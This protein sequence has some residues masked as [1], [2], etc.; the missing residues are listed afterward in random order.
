MTFFN[1]SDSLMNISTA[2][3]L[4]GS[5]HKL[6]FQ[7]PYSTGE[8][9][10]TVK[11]WGMLDYDPL[12]EVHNEYERFQKLS[13]EEKMELTKE[14]EIEQ[15][16]QD[17]IPTLLY[18]TNQVV[19]EDLS[20]VEQA[21]IS[22]K[23]LLGADGKCLE[24]Y[25][26]NPTC[27]RM[28]YF[29]GNELCKYCGGTQR[30]INNNLDGKTVNDGEGEKLETLKTWYLE[31]LDQDIEFVQADQLDQEVLDPVEPAGWLKQQAK[32]SK[33]AFQKV[34]KKAHTKVFGIHPTG[35][36]PTE[37]PRRFQRDGIVDNVF[38]PDR[39]IKASRYCRGEPDASEPI[40]NE[41]GEPI[42]VCQRF[43]K[44]KHYH[45]FP[46]LCEV[47]NVIPDE[48]WIARDKAIENANKKRERQEQRLSTE[49]LKWVVIYTRKFCGEE[50]V[51]KFDF[52]K[53]SEQDGREF[54]WAMNVTTN[55]K[56]EPT[57]ALIRLQRKCA[58]VIDVQLAV[59]GDTTKC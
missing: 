56:A 36:L 34:F 13:F 50:G 5:G 48:Y 28:Q 30:Y 21:E 19:F 14:P 18:G 58:L 59:D 9:L 49:T 54:T 25:C 32:Y 45:N 27:R 39:E 20:D 31:F 57:E 53:L 41:F 17:I 23:L 4:E 52:N 42:E 40:I 35:N 26:P 47:D 11:I 10:D 1:C 6:C 55:K 15:S 2:K 29:E 24:M 16:D 7:I 8:G 51:K 12:V 43:C 22:A 33:S 44:Q 38:T 37:A 46:I 3:M